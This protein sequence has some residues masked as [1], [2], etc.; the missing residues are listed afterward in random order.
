MLAVVAAAEENI[1]QI[2]HTHM[3]DIMVVV[4]G[5]IGLIWRN[6]SQYCGAGG[7]GATTVAISLNGTDGRL[8]SYQNE[9]IAS[10]YI[11]GVAGGG[12]GSTHGKIQY[13]SRD[14]RGG[15]TAE[16]NVFGLGESGGDY[17]ATTCNRDIPSCIEGSGGGG[18]RLV[19][20]KVIYWTSR[21]S[22]H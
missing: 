18:R 19:W 5:G 15:A 16:R 2:L 3:E 1:T 13:T 6:L 8:Q 9:S 14:C 21:T 20:W 12:G 17:S 7:G 4:T 11:L 10:Q 22:Q